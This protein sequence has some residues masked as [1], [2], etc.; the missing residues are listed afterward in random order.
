MFESLKS[1]KVKFTLGGILI[2]IGGYLE[3]TIA[4]GVAINTIVV[5]I[6]AYVGV[7]GVADAISRSKK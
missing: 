6:L 5:L 1:R 2:A 7:E 4:P 3:G